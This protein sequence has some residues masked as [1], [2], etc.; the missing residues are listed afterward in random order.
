MTHN[1]QPTF[2]K[3]C[4]ITRLGDARV[5]ARAGANAIGFVFAP[6]SRR[7][8]VASA[9]EIGAHIHPTLRKIGVFVD[10][11]LDKVLSIADEAGL[12]GVQL[13]GVE[14][15][16]FIVELKRARPSLFVSKVLRANSRK[17][18]DGLGRSG[19]DAILVDRKD[20]YDPAS[21][22]KPVPISW[23]KECRFEHLIVAGGLGPG[24]VGRLVREV[25]PW[26]VDVSSGV[27]S[28]PGRKDPEKIRAFVRAVRG[29]EGM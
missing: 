29:A 10:S 28:A 8:S 2:I 20:P 24:N 27:E 25:R 23:L 15:P 21:V 7:V 26:G 12:D 5:A 4:G 17:A 9:R 11:A 19:A 16:T 13:Q 3:I 6:S 14:S 18:L 1:E 22:S